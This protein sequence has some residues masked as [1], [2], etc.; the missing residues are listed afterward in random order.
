MAPVCRIRLSG[1]DAWQKLALSLCAVVPR[2]PE[3][4]T[5][6]VRPTLRLGCWGAPAGSGRR[7]W[8]P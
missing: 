7:R 2:Q 6:T 1:R 8:P 5:V 3:L 4:L